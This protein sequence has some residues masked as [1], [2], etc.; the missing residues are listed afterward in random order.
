M[1]VIGI[2]PSFPAVRGF[3]GFRR[4]EGEGFCS[5]TRPW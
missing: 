5:T 3:G 4:R 1:L 2:S